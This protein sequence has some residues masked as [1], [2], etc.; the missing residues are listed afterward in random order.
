[1]ASPI[2]KS[3]YFENRSKKYYLNAVFNSK[4]KNPAEQSDMIKHELRVVSYT[5]RV[6]SLKAWAEIQKSQFKSKSYKFKSMS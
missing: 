5:L 3:F 1:M 4:V 2:Y 6:E